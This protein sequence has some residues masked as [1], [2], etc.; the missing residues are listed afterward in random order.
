MSKGLEALERIKNHSSVSID[1]FYEHFGE[2]L[3]TIEKELKEYEMEHTLRVRLEN[4]N[5]ELVREK[6]ENENKLKAF[7][8]IKEHILY[9]ENVDCFVFVNITKEVNDLLKEIL[10]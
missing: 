3:D 6:Q 2:D 10:L 5:Y 4:I 8:I 9:C 7:E 1:Y